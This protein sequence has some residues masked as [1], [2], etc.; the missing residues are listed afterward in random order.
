MEFVSVVWC[1]ICYKFPFEGVTILC[2]HVS[3]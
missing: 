2:V 3:K 1:E